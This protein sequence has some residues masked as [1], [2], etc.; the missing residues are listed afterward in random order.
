MTEKERVKTQR[1][2]YFK[3]ATWKQKLYYFWEY[4]KI[5][6]ISI[7]LIVVVVSSFIYHKVTDP[8]IILNGIFLNTNTLENEKTAEDL[9]LEFLESKKID[10]SDY[11]VNFN[12]GLYLTGD[13]TLD[14]EGEQAVWVQCGAGTVDFI[15][16]PVE[17]LMDFAYQEYYAD[18][19]SI[20]TE[21]QLK[22]YEPYFLYVD[23]AVIEEM[24]AAPADAPLDDIE[25]PD[26]TK[27]EE[28][29]EPI[30]V[31]IDMTQFEKLTNLYASDTDSLVFC[32][33][34]NA[35]DS[36]LAI[37]FLEYLTE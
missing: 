11:T 37:D 20:L 13:S 5:H 10:T 32:I 3:N 8:E 6:T 31:F 16:S 35:P 24:A 36:E 17:H 29:D 34:V 33:L 14:Y 18:L 26:P 1:K 27:P 15:V 19:T 4:Y 23:G 22:K 12:E 7:I 21:E 9:G 28:M 30:P 2:E 25:L